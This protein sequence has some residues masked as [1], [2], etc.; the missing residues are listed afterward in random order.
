MTKFIRITMINGEKWEVPAEF[1]IKDRAKHLAENDSKGDLE[2][3]NKVYEEEYKNAFNDNDLIV[4]W[5]RNNT[6]WKD[7]E[8]LAFKV[9]PP[10]PLTRK[11]KETAWGSGEMTVVSRV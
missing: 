5:A 8:N 2:I 6:D 11:D 4:E 1:V 9:S 10:P 7:V 3:Y